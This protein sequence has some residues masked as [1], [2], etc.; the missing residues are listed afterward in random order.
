M[1]RHPS[2]K[3][4]V[5]GT[6]ALDTMLGERPAAG[7]QRADEQQR[8]RGIEAGQRMRLD[9]PRLRIGRRRGDACDGRI[10]K[11]RS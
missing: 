6:H 4:K 9:Q 1:G 7:T 11:P 3:R 10:R 5:C 8:P 2:Q